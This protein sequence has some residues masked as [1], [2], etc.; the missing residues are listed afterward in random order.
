MLKD[1][2]KIKKTKKLIQWSSSKRNEIIH[3]QFAK[4]ITYAKTGW[5]VIITSEPYWKNKIS[6]KYFKKKS[7]AL[8]Y[9]RN[10]M[11]KR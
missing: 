3:I 8:S 5:L 7:K 6:P 1:W 9:A 11:R 2:K 4:K 10:Y